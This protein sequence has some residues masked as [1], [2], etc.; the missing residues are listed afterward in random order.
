M[1]GMDGFETCRRLR[2]NPELARLPVVFLTAS[3]HGEDVARRIA[4]GGD[5]FLA[6]RCD[7][8]ALLGRIAYWT[9]HSA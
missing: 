6:K 4:T 5:D 7:E 1:P 8:S 2:R 3:R 9:A